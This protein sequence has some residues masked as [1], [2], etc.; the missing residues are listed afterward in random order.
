MRRLQPCLCFATQ[1]ADNNRLFKEYSSLLFLDL[2][3][4]QWSQKISTLQEPDTQKIEKMQG[5]CCPCFWWEKRFSR[6]KFHFSQRSTCGGKQE[7]RKHF[8]IR[9][10]CIL[11]YFLQAEQTEILK[12]FFREKLAV[13]KTKRAPRWENACT[14]DTETNFEQHFSSLFFL[15]RRQKREESTKTRL[16]QRAS[17]QR[18]KCKQSKNPTLHISGFVFSFRSHTGEGLF[19]WESYSVSSDGDTVSNDVYLRL[20]QPGRHHDEPLRA[21]LPSQPIQAP[22]HP[23]SLRGYVHHSKTKQ[24]TEVRR[25]FTTFEAPFPK[26]AFGKFLDSCP[27]V[28]FISRKQETWA[29]RFLKK[30]GRMCFEHN[31]QDSKEN[32][33]SSHNWHPEAMEI[34]A[35]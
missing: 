9:A 14:P 29:S 19:W 33:L 13:L 8:D 34:F 35:Y 12:Y 11:T 21:H 22:V 5:T 10:L 4:F 16:E 17:F 6:N 23:Q 27:R 24:K 2:A 32:H 25:G 18:R 26:Q 31:A 15:G 28:S 30:I 7:N 20:P 3:V 1:T